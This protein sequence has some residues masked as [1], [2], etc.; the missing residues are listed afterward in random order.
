MMSGF[1]PY[2]IL[3]IFW[4]ALLKMSGFAPPEILANFG[5]PSQRCP[6]GSVASHS[7]HCLLCLPLCLA[8]LRYLLSLRLS[9]TTETH[10]HRDTHTQQ[11]SA[12]LV[13]SVAMAMTVHIRYQLLSC[14]NCT[15]HNSEIQGF[16]F[17]TSHIA[18]PTCPSSRSSFGHVDKLSDQSTLVSRWGSHLPLLNQVRACGTINIVRVC[19]KASP[20]EGFRQAFVEHRRPK[21]DDASHEGLL[22]VERREFRWFRW[23]RWFR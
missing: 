7:V 12:G 21:A 22:K 15:T 9:T 18:Q 1:T 5:P 8:S 23:F 2:S 10:D 11:F 17:C 13:I 3:A 6:A 20:A 19:V 4:A 14:T 16:L